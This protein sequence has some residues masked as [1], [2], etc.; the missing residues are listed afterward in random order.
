M[1][2]AK[3]SIAQAWLH[4]WMQRA[5]LGRS[6]RIAAR[7]AALVAEP[8][9]SR[10]SLARRYPGGF[11]APS[12]QVAAADVRLGWN[13]Y[14]GDRVV[15]YR[16]GS[17]EPVALGDKVEIHN[18]T[19]LEVGAGGRITIDAESGIQPRCQ[20]NSYAAPIVIGRYV[21]IAAGC[22]LY[23]Y[24]HGTAPG[25][26]MRDQPLTTRGPIVIED[27]AWI[28]T[29]VIIL[30][31]VTIGAGAVVGAGSVV[32]RSIPAGAIALGSPARVVKMRGEP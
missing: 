2:G 17:G 32:T 29:G 13:V 7:M 23:A 6:G 24:D 26:L 18:D 27:D 8:Y 31:G 25:T 21:Q 20:I 22:A 9:K 11:I 19:I 12:A 30:S 28:G 14:L 10:I 1:S 15:I 3:Q 16:R 5:G 4:F